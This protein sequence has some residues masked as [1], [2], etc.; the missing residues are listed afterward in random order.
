[1]SIKFDFR[2]CYRNQLA[3]FSVPANC[4]LIFTHKM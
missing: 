2:K 4:R 3:Y 1:M